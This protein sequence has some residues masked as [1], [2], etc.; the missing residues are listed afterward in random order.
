LKKI[1]KI[2]DERLLELKKKVKLDWR[3]KRQLLIEESQKNQKEQQ[4][5]QL[6]EENKINHGS[7]R[8]WVG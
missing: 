3:T 2:K 8:E 6:I 1:Q 4:V 7:Q 5:A